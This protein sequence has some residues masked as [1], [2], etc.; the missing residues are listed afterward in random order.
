VIKPWGK[1]KRTA[2]VK[3]AAQGRKSYRSCS[4]FPWKN[5]KKNDRSSKDAANNAAQGRNKAIEAT[6]LFRVLNDDGQNVVVEAHCW[7]LY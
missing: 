3:N 6:L 2:V 7:H 1:K 4:S 5:L